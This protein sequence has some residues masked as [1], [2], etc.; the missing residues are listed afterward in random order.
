MKRLSVKPFFFRL[1]RALPMP[2]IALLVGLLAGLLVWG[3]LDQVQSRQVSK[4]FATELRTQLEQSSRE[5]LIR[6]DRYMSSY[7]TTTRLLASHRRLAEYLEP[8]L[9]SPEQQVAPVVYRNFRPA[10]LPD[11]FG[12]SGLIPPSHVV[13]TD[14]QGRVRE[15]YQAGKAPLPEELLR[16]IGDQLQDPGDVRPGWTI[17]P[18]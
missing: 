2:V 7:V 18:T 16:G 4:I 17:G 12:R 13:L 8:L 5:S 14:R 3:V 1:L 15:V 10:W 9:W 11:L 6:F